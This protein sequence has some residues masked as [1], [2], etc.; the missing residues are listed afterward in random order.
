M[1]SQAQATAISPDLRPREEM[2]IKHLEI[3][4]GV[5]IRMAANSF[6]LKGWTITLSSA[7]FA[8]AAKDSNANFTLLA[9]FPAGAFW[10]LDAYYLRQERLFRKLY[11]S[12]C[13]TPPTVTPWCL[14]TTG[15]RNQ[16]PSFFKTLWA[17]PLLLLHGSVVTAMIVVL[18][19]LH[20]RR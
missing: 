13:A 9:L 14:D 6:L 5:I 1:G 17:I 8:L 10:A 18:L 11:E 3:I 7:L 2:L 4:Q 19:V 20:W 12:A 16:V 15:Y